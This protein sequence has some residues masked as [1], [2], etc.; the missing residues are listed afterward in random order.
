MVDC[1]VTLYENRNLS[2]K[3]LQG[4]IE[5]LRDFLKVCTI[6]SARPLVELMYLSYKGSRNVSD[7]VIIDEG[8][9]FCTCETSAIISY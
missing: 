8:L 3:V 4:S 6:R 1:G 2:S 5:L 7:T 9:K